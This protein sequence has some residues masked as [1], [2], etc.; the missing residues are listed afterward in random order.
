MM[1]DDTPAC[2]GFAVWLLVDWLAAGSNMSSWSTKRWGTGWNPPNLGIVLEP[3]GERLQ[4]SG[5]FLQGDTVA[6]AANLLTM[7][8]LPIVW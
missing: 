5:S 4:K 7:E 3:R 2:R 8:V 1:L 6:D